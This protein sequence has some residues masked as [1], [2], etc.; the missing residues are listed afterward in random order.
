MATIYVNSYT[1]LDALNCNEW[2]RYVSVN[3]ITSVTYVYEFQNTN[4]RHQDL[5]TD[6][7]TS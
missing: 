6:K 1:L 3:I 4:N 2:K 7:H 5:N